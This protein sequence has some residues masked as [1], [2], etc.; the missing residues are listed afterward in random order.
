MYLVRPTLTRLFWCRVCGA[1]A[2]KAISALQKVC[3]GTRRPGASAAC[4]RIARSIHPQYAQARLGA[5]LEFMPL[6]AAVP[7][8][9]E[10]TNRPS[11]PAWL[12]TGGMPKG[13]RGGAGACGGPKKKFTPPIIKT[14]SADTLKIGAP[15]CS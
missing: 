3:Q 10:Q 2:S 14:T 11:R 1:Y 15:C 5:Y 7:D 6:D 4:S 12:L 8:G 13:R 9:R